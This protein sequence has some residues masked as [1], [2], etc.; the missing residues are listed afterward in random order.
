MTQAVERRVED[1]STDPLLQQAV[2]NVGGKRRPVLGGVPLQY[3][4]ADGMTGSLYYGVHPRLNR[5][6]A[7]K[8]MPVPADPGRL[9]QLMA[10]AQAALGVESPRLVE[11]FD[12]GVE[13]AVVFFVTEH[14][15]GK[16]AEQHLS[17]LRQR[18]K[19]GFDEAPAL[20][21]CVA[22]ATGLGAAHQANLLHLCL[23][24]SSVFIP[25]AASAGTLDFVNAKL[26]DLGRAYSDFSGRLL[27]GTAAETGVP[28][29]MAPEQ[30]AGAANLSPAT[31]VFS[32]GAVMYMLL[33]GQAPYDG[34]SLEVILSATA[35][36]EAQDLRTWRPD[37][38][39]ATAKVIEICL[40]KNA[41]ARF[42][43]ATVL[44]QALV[45]CRAAR[46]ELLDAQVEAV[47]QI[48][49]LVQAAPAQ[50][51]APVAQQPTRTVL[52]ALAP[53]S[54]LATRK[55]VVDLPRPPE[56][57][58]PEEA[59]AAVA[60]AT[61]APAE[62]PAAAAVA[63]AADDSE[64]TMLSAAAP[65]PE[66]EPAVAPPAEPPAAEPSPDAPPPE[67]TIE[68]VPGSEVT[69]LSAATAPPQAAEPAQA[70]S[71]EPAEASSAAPGEAAGAE[72]TMPPAKTA[73]VEWHDPTLDEHE[74]P[75]YARPRRFPVALVAALFL[76]IC[77]AVAWEMG[78]LDSLLKPKPRT[79]A[80]AVMP[81]PPDQN[82]TP[83]PPGKE[84]GKQ[85][86]D[87]Q[88][89]AEQDRLAAEARK[90][91]AAEK[92]AEEKRQAEAKAKAEQ[93]R[94]AEEARKKGAAEKEAEEKR[95]A[96]AKA[97]AE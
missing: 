92:E 73:L 51:Q 59:V 42:A 66:A 31:D 7:V 61:D 37:V 26:N 64:L 75:A 56:E 33:L 1:L 94:L 63:A 11:L 68:I 80:G 90:T 45:I 58:V 38:S 32:F 77:G 48:E 89:K 2:Q 79:V 20:D 44:R 50:P 55:T 97:K 36:H 8:V 35:I 29:F 74:A 84:D 22:A 87:T 53:R 46:E 10:Q 52:S 15:Q 3:K 25:E 70:S 91:E 19:S 21:T 82:V 14:V 17:T 41:L 24:P 47:A 30:V 49:A 81:T 57:E 95:Q 69:M 60:P 43:D 65:P 78:W 88:G 9:E 16:S 27:A 83:A 4:I 62:A 93:D 13:A 67:D 72:A 39:R 40:R 86:P 28:G 6:V 71:A 34:P 18:L 76:V 85:P 12:A 5:P 54:D 23:R 96:E